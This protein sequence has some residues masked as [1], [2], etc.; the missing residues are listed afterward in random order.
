MPPG[1][2]THTATDIRGRE[3]VLRL[4]REHGEKLLA[5]RDVF[6]LS[7]CTTWHRSPAAL[8]DVIAPA[9]G[10]PAGLPRVPLP[11][12]SAA[13]WPWRCS[14]KTPS[15]RRWLNGRPAAWLEDDLQLIHHDYDVLMGAEDPNNSLTRGSPPAPRVLLL[16]CDRDVGLQPH[17][18]EEA[19]AWTEGRYEAWA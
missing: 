18:V 3:F 14:P 5:L 15:V 8:D 13:D 9:V 7:W 1:F 6:D 17:H 4:N 10:L 16:K 11:S 19:R 2:E 12:G